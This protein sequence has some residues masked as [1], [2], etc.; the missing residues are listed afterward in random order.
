MLKTDFGAHPLSAIEFQREIERRAFLASGD[1]RAP[2]QTVGDFLNGT[3]SNGFTR[4]Q[5]TYPHGVVATHLDSIL[6]DFVSNMLKIGLRRFG[7]THSFFN[8]MNAPLTGVET[9]TSS[10]VRIERLENFT[11]TGFEHIYP[12]GEG[13]GWAGGITSAAVDGLKCAEAYIK[14]F[15]L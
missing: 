15:L 13:A 6:P 7:S 9:R 11:V 3:K 14:E 5:P 12:C 10:P 2:A 8:D 4:V 1:F